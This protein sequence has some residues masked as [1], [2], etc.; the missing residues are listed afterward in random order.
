MLHLV[1]NLETGQYRLTNRNRELKNGIS[2]TSGH[3]REHN[4]ERIP[5]SSKI[6]QAHIS[7]M[8]RSYRFLMF[9]GRLNSIKNSKRLK[10][11]L[12]SLVKDW[13]LGNAEVFLRNKCIW[14]KT[15]FYCIKSHKKYFSH[16]TLASHNKRK[17]IFYI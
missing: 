2:L 12:L 16:Q 13:N 6:K 10:L 4:N 11:Q 3:F 5:K 9:D 17:T 8:Q 14:K 1:N 7:E 15:S